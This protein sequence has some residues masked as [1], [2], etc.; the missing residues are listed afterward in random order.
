MSRV[1]RTRQA[2]RAAYDRLSRWYDLFA[3]S[4]EVY[5]RRGLEMLGVSASETVLE[6]GFGTGHSLL[7]LAGQ[8]GIGGRV[9]GIDLSYGMAREARERVRKSGLVA[10]CEARVLL[11]QGDASRLPYPAEYFDAVFIA[12]TLELFDTPEIPRVLQEIYRVLRSSGRF[13]V[14]S[15]SLPERPGRMVRLYEWLHQALPA[16]VD[17]RPI[18]VAALVRQN[19]FTVRQAACDS[20]W[21]LPV[22]MVCGVKGN[23]TRMNAKKRG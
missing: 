11:H 17:C 9:I 4:E 8:V 22:E 2:A 14:V 20:M 21:G 7:A 12:F 18:P 13:N 16:W 6:I 1:T 5:N 23:G 10:S 19:G 3:G 15:L